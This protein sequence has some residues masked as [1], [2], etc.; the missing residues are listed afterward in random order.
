MTAAPGF[1][2]A[3]YDWPVSQNWPEP[4][5]L[6][7]PDGASEVVL[8]C[9][10]ASNH[11]PAEYQG[12]GLEEPDLTR[13]IAWDIGA[14]DVA[15]RLSARLDA[16][17]FVAHYSRLLIDL[18]R[19]HA[20]MSA[21]PELSESTVIPGN[22]ALDMAERTRRIAR[23][24]TPFHA[25]IAGVLNQR[26]ATGR[27]TLLIS[28]HSF[29]PVYKGVTRPWHIGIL[30][31]EAARAG[32]TMVAQLAADPALCVGTNEPYQIETDSDYAIPVHGDQRGI[33][34]LLV[35]LRNDLI[36]TSAGAE[37]WADRLAAVIPAL[38]SEARS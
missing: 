17:L 14:E 3:A 11:M 26:Q 37:E 31:G 29:T 23:I 30:Y 20:A 2:T 24:F 32:E 10:H 33:P 15:R 12:L 9:E 34:A 27:P 28:I 38:A 16:P 21:F 13:H 6:I 18:N 22:V 19:P 4:V 7:N 1:H 36:A 35:E 5:S 25:R 8:I